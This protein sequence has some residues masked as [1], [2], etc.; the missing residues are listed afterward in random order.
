VVGRGGGGPHQ[1]GVTDQELARDPGAA[2]VETAAEDRTAPRFQAI[3]DEDVGADGCVTEVQGGQAGRIDLGPAQVQRAADPGAHQPDLAFRGELVGQPDRPADAEPVGLDGALAWGGDRGVQA[4]QQAADVG[5]AQ[6]DRRLPGDAGA[7]GVQAGHGG[8]R[9]V[10]VTADAQAVA[11]EA[12]ERNGPGQSQFS[13]LGARHDHGRVEL[14]VLEADRVGHLQSGQVEWAG[15]GGV[16]EP[17]APWVD[18]VLQLQAAPAQQGRVDRAAADGRGAVRGGTGR[19]RIGSARG[20]GRG[21]RAVQHPSLPPGGKELGLTDL[22]R[23]GFHGVLPT[24]GDWG[25][26]KPPPPLCHATWASGI[27]RRIRLGQAGEPGR[28]GPETR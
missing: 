28:S 12:G 16:P 8:S 6:P 20:A 22:G 19:R 17:E 14:A 1:S 4:Q 9:Q 11:E 18:L 25:R 27:A 13:Q 26:R 10:E 21:E 2:H 7:G 23:A 24:L 5:L 15:H 3:G